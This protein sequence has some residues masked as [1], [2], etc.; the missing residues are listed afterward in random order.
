[1]RLLTQIALLSVSTSSI[2]EDVTA[3]IIAVPLVDSLVDSS[4]KGG[5]LWASPPDCFAGWH[6]HMPVIFAFC[7]GREIA[8]ANWTSNVL[9]TRAPV[10]SNASA[11]PNVSSRS[12]DRL[13]ALFREIAVARAYYQF[14]ETA[15]AHIPGDQCPES[16]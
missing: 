8:S 11:L 13:G 4:A 6:L 14:L 7:H 10:Y 5:C 3:S 9:R 16:A 2:R 1:M 12:Q 15:Y